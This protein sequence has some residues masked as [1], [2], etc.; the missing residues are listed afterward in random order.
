M[1][2]KKVKLP[3]CWYRESFSGLDKKTLS[4]SLIQNKA[5]TLFI[6]MKAERSDKA[7]ETK[8]EAKRGWFLRFK[9]EVISLT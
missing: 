8:S 6:S 1:R 5:L 3:Y 4:Q 2:N 7:T 9:E